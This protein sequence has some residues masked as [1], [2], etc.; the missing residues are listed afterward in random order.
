MLISD[1]S[2]SCSCLLAL[3]MSLRIKT[4][5]DEVLELGFENLGQKLVYFNRLD[6]I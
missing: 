3:S 4:T 6:Q 5:R 1:E 2:T